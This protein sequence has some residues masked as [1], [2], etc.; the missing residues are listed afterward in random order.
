MHEMIGKLGKTELIGETVEVANNISDASKEGMEMVQK[1]NF[2]IRE[3]SESIRQTNDAI[4]AVSEHATSIVSVVATIKSIAE[5]TNLLALN[6]AIE[7]ARAG[8]HGRGFAVVADEVRGLSIKTSE[9][10]QVVQESIKTLQTNV[11]TT[12]SLMKQS[13]EDCDSSL[14]CVD[15]MNNAIHTIISTVDRINSST[16][17][18]RNA[19]AHQTQMIENTNKMISKV[20]SSNAML[21]RTVEENKERSRELQE[22]SES[23]TSEINIE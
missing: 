14:E 4:A 10:I 5:Q 15:S 18:I 17:T 22:T 1:S 16:E 8:E 3:L 19:T 2:S 21:I 11:D 23:I 7:S 6:A 20:N 12:V 13:I 9:S